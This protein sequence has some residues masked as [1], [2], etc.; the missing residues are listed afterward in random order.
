[1][2]AKRTQLSL[3]E[4]G[5]FDDLLTDA[6]VD[7][8]Y[9]WTKI[10]KTKRLYLPNRKITEQAVTQIISEHVVRGRSVTTAVEKFEQLSAVKAFI[11]GL[12]DEWKQSEFLKHARRYMQIYHPEAGFEVNS[13]T[14]YT[15]NT[16]EACVMARR[17]LKT[18][19][20]IKF[21]SGVMVLMTDEE[22]EN[23]DESSD[24]SIICTS[25]MKGTSVLLGPARFV[26]HDCNPNCKFITTN[27]DNVSLTVIR[28][29]KLGEEITIKYSDSYFGENN[30][31]C[32]CQTCE[33]NAQNGFALSKPR[34]VTEVAPPCESD[35]TYPSRPG[36]RGTRALGSQLALSRST[37]ASGRFADHAFAQQQSE[38]LNQISN[39]ARMPKQPVLTPPPSENSPLS[40]DE[41]KQQTGRIQPVQKLPDSMKAPLAAL[42][43]VPAAVPAQPP[44]P[45]TDSYSGSDE[46]DSDIDS[47]LSEIDEMEYQKLL[48]TFSPSLSAYKYRNK[49]KRDDTENIAPTAKRKRE[50]PTAESN[51]K[52]TKRKRD[53]G[54]AQDEPVAPKRTKKLDLPLPY[55]PTAKRFPGDSALV[56]QI[57]LECICTD[58]GQSF[59][60][61]ET[62]F[63]L[64]SCRRCERHSKVYGLVWPKTFKRKN[65]Q[66]P[67]ILDP[68]EI[69]RYITTAHLRRLL[70]KREDEERARQ[71]ERQ[72]NR[73][74]NGR[75]NATDRAHNP[76]ASSNGRVAKQP[77]QA[78]PKAPRP[79]KLSGSS[80]AR[81]AAVPV[82]MVP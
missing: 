71:L 12:N 76:D 30:C 18:G 23:L 43:Q 6:L 10:R 60:N 35:A 75:K 1:M 40:G 21:L 62:W 33:D 66:E 79:P 69:S 8:V 80:K 34:Q 55:K 36:R 78:A 5:E 24:F 14:R 27:K 37:S 46:Y 68:R 65:D 32:L 31:E 3:A 52:G 53:A 9:Y 47:E 72:R 51:S 44:S 19:E 63:V 74:S 81:K 56:P 13:T 54:E 50:K 15:L 22:E 70:R 38:D 49:R 41:S 73:R 77:T 57:G 59:W 48:D 20:T 45:N 39:A 29:I 25:R 64:R 28:D 11:D 61:T 17:P 7:K 2:A 4:L 58:C 16:P 42:R 26:N 67:E 82:I